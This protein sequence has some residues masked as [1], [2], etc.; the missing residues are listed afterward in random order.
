MTPIERQI[1]VNQSLGYLY[2]SRFLQKPCDLCEELNPHLKDCFKDKSTYKLDQVT[3]KV[4]DGSP[5]TISELNK[6]E[7]KNYSNF[8]WFL[9]K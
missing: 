4:I 9:N 7:E 5:E 6:R 8:D 3:G 2:K 1:L